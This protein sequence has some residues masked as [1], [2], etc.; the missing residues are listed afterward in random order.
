MLEGNISA[1]IKTE[2]LGHLS[3]VKSLVINKNVKLSEEEAIEF[4]GNWNLS[5]TYTLLDL[6]D[7]YLTPINVSQ[8]LNILAGEAENLIE[9]LK[10][11]GLIEAT[12][13]EGKYNAVPLHFDDSFVASADLLSLYSKVSQKSLSRLTS[14]DIFS[15]RF[16]AMSKKVIQKYQA[17]I[18]GLLV[19]IAEESKGKNDCELYA[20]GFFFSKIS[21]NRKDK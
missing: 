13:V 3:D 11:M 15:F 8:R 7:F 10:S 16:E 21:R 2:D 1:T 14:K 5:A 20:T 19:K 17:E 9:T 18:N 6:E 12:E 4:L